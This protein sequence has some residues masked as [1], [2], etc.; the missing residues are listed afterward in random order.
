MSSYGVRS[1]VSRLR[2]AALRRPAVTGDFLGAGWRPPQHDLLVRQHDEFASLL[3]GLGV[4]V[5]LLPADEGQV[6]SVFCYDPGFVIGSGLVEFRSAKPVRRL[7]GASLARALG[8]RRVP[9]IAS[10]KVP[11]VMD[12]GDLCWIARDLVVAGRS[13]RTNQGAHDFMRRLLEGEGQQLLSFDMPHDLGPDHVLHL[14]S[15]ISPITDDLVVVYPRILPVPLMQLLAERGIQTLEVGFDEYRT[16]GGNILAVEP[17]VVVIFAGNPN[18]TKALRDKGVEVHEIDASEI[19]KGD[20]G[21]TCLTRP[22][23]RD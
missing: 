19:A 16:F 21:P 22:I 17:G 20:G 14:M 1:S 9:T 2:R 23:R 5:E 15:G 11:A 18:I 10:M 3:A 8:E 7:E 4:A 13:Y 12:G 6:D